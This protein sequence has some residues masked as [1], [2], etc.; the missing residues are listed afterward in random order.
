MSNLV[1]K[2]M[3]V[4]VLL[5]MVAFSVGAAPAQK[6]VGTAARHSVGMGCISVPAGWQIS[7]EEH[8]GWASGQIRGPAGSRIMAFTIGTGPSAVSAERRGKFQ[9]FR[10]EKLRDSVLNY[11]LEKKEDGR[12][13]LQASVIHGSSNANFVTPERDPQSLTDLLAV[14]RSYSWGKCRE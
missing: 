9:W 2:R 5:V 8:A 14:A 12:G 6:K 1:P 3:S 4:A 10:S 11:A 13:V 7:V